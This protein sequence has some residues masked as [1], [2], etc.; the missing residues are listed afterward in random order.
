MVR[1]RLSH[2][3]IL[4]R[5]GA[6][7]MGEVFVAEDTKLERRVALK[8]LPAAVSGDPERLERFKREAR[9][10][11]AINH[12]GVVTLHAVEEAEGVHFLTMELVEGRTL[13]REIPPDGLPLARFFEIA[14][15]LA[16]AVRAAHEKGVVHRDLKPAN[17]MLTEGGRLKVLDFGL[18]RREVAT[19][20]TDESA[21]PTERLLTRTGQ[22]MGTPHYMS[23]EQVEALPADHRSDLFS[24]GVILHQMAVGARP[25]EG[26]SPVSVM[27][28]ILTQK[29]PPVS[30]LRPELPRALARIIHHCLEKKPERRFQTALDLR[31]ELERLAEE[32]TAPDA[33]ASARLAPAAATAPTGPTV[34]ATPDRDPTSP[35]PR[36]WTWWAGAAALAALAALGIVF[37]RGT[38]EREPAPADRGVRPVS[39]L[40]QVTVSAAVDEHPAWS[41]DGRR[42]AFSREVDGYFKIFD[43][44]L[45]TGA[46]RQ[47]TEGE[48][49]DI[50]PA[51]SPDGTALLFVRGNQANGKIQ[52]SD[53]YG[54]HDDAD[55]WRLELATGKLIK[56]AGQAFHPAFSPDGQRVAFYADWAGPYRIWI[57][58]PFGRNPEQVTRDDSEQISHLLPRWSPDGTKIVFQNNHWTTKFDIRVVDVA[59]GEMRWVTDDAYTDVNP[60][61]S[62]DNAS[63]YF[64]SYRSGGMNVWRV[65][66]GGDGSPIGP[67]EQVTTGAGADIQPAISPVDGKLAFSVT[68]GN[69]DIW[70]LPV[71]PESGRPTGEPEPLVVT[72]REDS[73]AA[74]S[75]DGRRVAFNSDRSGNM[76][77]WILSRDDGSTRQVTHG[78]GGDFQANWS[79][80][81]ERL[82]FFS[83]RAGNADVWTVDL[84]SGELSQLT[85]DPAIDINPF[86]SPDGRWIVFQSDRGGRREAWLMRADGSEERQLT[87]NTFGGV[88]YFAWTGDSREVMF[89]GAEGGTWKVPVEG[90]DPVLVSRHGG[91]HM[92]LSPDRSRILDNDHRALFVTEARPEG[93]REKVFEFDDPSISIDYSV[94]SPD[95]RTVLFDR[96]D[97]EA[98]DIWLLE[99]ER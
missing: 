81:G 90:G 87:S 47:L 53:P 52:L 25:F 88:H 63:I 95:G 69:A 82:A 3:R 54:V 24:L 66:V 17:V 30:E 48:V 34:P 46:E 92:S 44:D 84:T 57:S 94:W 36:R 4:G 61:W 75:P 78:P 20:L 51:W 62:A 98:G 23:P 96:L 55:I 77:L 79:P 26:A 5:I 49:D 29:P 7:G 45:E 22:V 2:Y 16:E 71:D 56:I 18:A 15:P 42:L 59:T 11:A 37:L 97:P 40:R 65:P 6:G 31:N 64:S 32:L 19:G 74:W 85:S 27:S 13:D 21:L 38:P 70:R 72:T 50:H 99:P 33:A 83:M 58:D 86:F 10:A 9:A 14:L 67:P 1:D 80:D 73:R 91:W 41:A 12:P 60:T 28:A 8:V 39:K 35:T 43:L 68:R 76:N 93:E 89:R